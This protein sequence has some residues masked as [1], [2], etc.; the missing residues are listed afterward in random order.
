M[1]RSPCPRAHHYPFSVSH[2]SNPLATSCKK[3]THWKR[4]QCW[5]RLRAEGGNRG[6]DSWMYRGKWVDDSVFRGRGGVKPYLCPSGILTKTLTREKQLMN[7]CSTHSS[8]KKKQTGWKELPAGWRTAA[9]NTDV[10]FSCCTTS[11]WSSAKI[12]GQRLRTADKLSQRWRL[13]G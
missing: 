3:L 4:P 12:T 8:G 11:A 2:P 6:E 5:E 13:R 1:Q 7:S 9:L 10:L